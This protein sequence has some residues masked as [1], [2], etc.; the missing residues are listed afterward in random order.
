VLT[1]PA[2]ASLDRARSQ[3]TVALWIKPA[4]TTGDPGLVALGARGG[5][6]QSWGFYVRGAELGIFTNFPSR[7]SG[8]Y[9]STSA[10]ADIKAG[11]WAH[12]AFVLDHDARTTRYYK[13]GA[14]VSSHPHALP[15]DQLS[16]PLTL[17]SEAG[18]P[19]DYVGQLD[20]VAVWSR[21]LSAEEVAAVAREQVLAHPGILGTGTTCAALAGTNP[22][23]ASGISALDPDGP[24]GV[25]PFVTRCD[26][27]P[28]DAGWTLVANQAPS[29]LVD[30]LTSADFNPQH[31]GSLAATFRFGNARVQAFRPAVGWRMRSA[32]TAG[33][34][35]DE[36]FFRPAC[37]CATAPS[38]TL[39][40]ALDEACGVAWTS[41]AFVSR[42]SAYTPQNCSLG[43]GQN[44][45]GGYCSMRMGT[46]SW[47]TVPSGAAVPCDVA[48]ARSLSVQ[49]WVK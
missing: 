46:V 25:A 12:V 5:P 6:A 23:L 43:I 47:G 32:D 8:V 42:V 14:L 45:G 41:L 35:V 36:G 19:S 28:G 4:I 40:S 34:V 13:N 21:A 2:S 7:S 9:D 26:M 48:Q 22:G 44:N 15:L 27:S 31:D 1:A 20:D 38:L 49:L 3:L 17:C 11:E 29:A 10:G 30:A 39:V 24:G 37:D 16:L 33:R 18:S